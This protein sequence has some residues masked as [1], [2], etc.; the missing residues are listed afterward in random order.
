MNKKQLSERDVCTKFIVPA[1]GQADWDV[2]TQVRQE[3][4][5]TKERFIVH[6]HSRILLLMATGKTYTAFK[7]IW[8]LWKVKAKKRILFLADRNILVDQ[9]MLRVNQKQGGEA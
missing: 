9:T 4:P 2:A 1:L 6:G 7:I 5:L 8:R 3:C